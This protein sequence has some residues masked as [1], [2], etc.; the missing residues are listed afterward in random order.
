MPVMIESATAFRE[1]VDLVVLSA[2]TFITSTRLSAEPIR[3]E[4]TNS[5]GVMYAKALKVIFP[6]SSEGR[7]IMYMKVK[8]L[9]RPTARTLWSLSRSASFVAY[10]RMERVCLSI[11][12]ETSE[13]RDY[14]V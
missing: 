8:P 10:D 9:A 6:R 1:Q 3:T 11:S 12:R 5:M 4:K 14:V 13:V 7:R 2:Y